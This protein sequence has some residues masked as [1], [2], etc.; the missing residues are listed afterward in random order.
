MGQIIPDGVTVELKI[1]SKN[2]N[3]NY[4]K[5][6]YNGQVQFKLNPDLIPNGIYNIEVITGGISRKIKNV[7]L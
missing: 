4:L 6:S 3:E 1:K 2:I 7:K 5:Q